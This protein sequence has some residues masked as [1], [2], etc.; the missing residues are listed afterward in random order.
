MLTSDFF[1]LSLALQTALGAGYLSYML[2]YSGRRQGQAQSDVVFISLVF[3]AIAMIVFDLVGGWFE[4]WQ[5]AL[6]SAGSALAAALFWRALLRRCWQKIAK[7]LRIS[8]D[9]GI[10]LGWTGFLEYLDIEKVR[11]ISVRLKDGRELYCSEVDSYGSAHPTKL[12]L[13][14]DGGVGLVVE[15]IHH[16]DGTVED[17]RIGLVADGWGTR[18]TYIHASE[19]VSIEVRCA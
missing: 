11:Q 2:A 9:D 4:G 10:S 6:V 19:I 7:R 8:Q 5:A 13:G 16:K 18:T 1:N 17:R 15:E 12:Y 14:A 3:A